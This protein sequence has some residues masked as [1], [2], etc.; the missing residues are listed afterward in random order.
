MNA[1]RSVSNSGKATIQITFDDGTTAKVGGK[2]AAR[3]A[4]VVVVHSGERLR[5]N[6]SDLGAGWRV[7]GCR[8]S[9]YAAHSLVSSILNRSKKFDGTYY[10][11]QLLDV[12]AV[13]VTD[14]GRAL[15][16]TAKS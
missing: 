10:G 16:E 11:R 3:A 9:I 6:S 13:V 14:A 12:Q 4:A 1:I 5:N 7:E 8:S 15:T 2:R